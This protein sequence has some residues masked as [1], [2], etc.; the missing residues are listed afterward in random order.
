MT[1]SGLWQNL[2]NSRLSKILKTS[3]NQWLKNFRK[4]LPKARTKRWAVRRWRMTPR[5]SALRRHSHPVPTF[6]ALRAMNPAHLEHRPSPRRP[7]HDAQSNRILRVGPHP[8][9]AV[10][11]H[12]QH[13]I[14]HLFVRP[15]AEFLAAV[16]P[17]RQG[18]VIH[19]ERLGHLAAA[20]VEHMAQKAHWWKSSPGGWAKH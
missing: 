12:Q 13:D 19:A 17:A 8:R 1:A 4:L 6:D 20:Q 16:L 15:A 3:I 14:P 10:V 9:R 7:R 5:F 18:G 11:Q 2:Q